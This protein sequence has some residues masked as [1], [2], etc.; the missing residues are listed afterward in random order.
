MAPLAE[1]ERKLGGLDP[2]AAEPAARRTAAV[3]AL[4]RPGEPGP[5]V[6]LMTRAERPGDRWSGQVSFPGGRAEERDATLLD[7]A[8]R[9]TQEEVGIDLRRVARPIGRLEPVRAIA[10]GKVLPLTIAP[11]VFAQVEPIE[12]SLNHE[13]SDAFW[14]PLGRAAT[15]ELDAD[16]EYRLGPVPMTFPSW[17]W[18]GRVVWG[19]TYRMLQDLLA[20]IT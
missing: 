3:A 18:Q 20:R 7:T 16:Y 11:F 8:I 2:A 17:R 19:L 10:R 12:W 1:L 13:A 9:E 15:G 14:F 5:D 6:L 4:L